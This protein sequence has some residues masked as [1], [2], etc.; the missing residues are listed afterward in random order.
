M[1]FTIDGKKFAS[2]RVDQTVRSRT[3]E[4]WTIT[5]T[6]PMDAPSTSMFGRCRSSKKAAS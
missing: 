5:N 6:S 4:E 3:I 1:S 2:D